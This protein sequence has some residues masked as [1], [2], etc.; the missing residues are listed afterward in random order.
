MNV[1]AER[2]KKNKYSQTVFPIEKRVSKNELQYKEK[3]E[4]RN[5]LL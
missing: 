4:N 3:D 5:S 2:F 1:L